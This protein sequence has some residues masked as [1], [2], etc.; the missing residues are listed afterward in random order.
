MR[1]AYCALRTPVIYGTRSSEASLSRNILHAYAYNV[2][3]F[4]SLR[5][6][7]PHAPAPRSAV[8]QQGPFQTALSGER[9]VMR[10]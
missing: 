1:C 3:D 5:S 9:V 6:C 10:T 2:I 8:E 4:P 7:Q